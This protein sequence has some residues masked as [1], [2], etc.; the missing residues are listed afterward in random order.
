M[1]Y[2]TRPGVF[3][4]QIKTFWPDNTENTIYIEE[5]AC[6][7]DI[8]FAIEN[9]WPGTSFEDIR[10]RSERIQTDCIGY[11]LYDPCDRTNFI[12]IERN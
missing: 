9:K 10:I 4:H 12:I 2:S 3:G 7:A 6:L 8:I 5:S 11:D 1:G